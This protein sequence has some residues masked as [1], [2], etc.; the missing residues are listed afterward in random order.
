[1]LTDFHI[2]K[3]LKNTVIKDCYG[4]TVYLDYF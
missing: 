3:D 2:M 1:M 4:V